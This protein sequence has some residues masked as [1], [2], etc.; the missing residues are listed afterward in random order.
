MSFLDSLWI[1]EYARN[2]A[3]DTAAKNNNASGRK[4]ILDCLHGCDRHLTAEE[5]Q[6]LKP[7]VFKFW[8]TKMKIEQGGIT[9]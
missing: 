6:E 3:P 4:Y 1:L 2:T 5:Q 8:Q 9:K 7:W